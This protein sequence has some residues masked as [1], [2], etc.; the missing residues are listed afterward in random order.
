M[1]S[2]FGIFINISL[3]FVFSCFY[4]SLFKIVKILHIVRH[5]GTQAMVP[6]RWSTALGRLRQ[7]DHKFMVN[8]G[9]SNEAL[10]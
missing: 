5:G 3:I 6:T 7:E 8:Q 1:H 2:P 10:S 4:I 9:Y